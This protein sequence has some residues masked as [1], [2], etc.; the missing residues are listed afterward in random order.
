V[1]MKLENRP[2]KN[3]QIWRLRCSN[4]V[5]FHPHFVSSSSSS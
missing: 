1:C 2:I 5:V 3:E 4:W